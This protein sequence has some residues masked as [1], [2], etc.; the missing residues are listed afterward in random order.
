MNSVSSTSSISTMNNKETENL[1]DEMLKKIKLRDSTQFHYHKD[2]KPFTKS[3]LKYLR[4][5]VSRLKL[6]KQPEQRSKEW[7][8]MRENKITASDIATAIDESKYQ[9]RLCIT[10]EKSNK[11]S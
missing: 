8:E 5:Q 2:L 4:E 6:I 1:S 3:R 11:R 7:F 9:K 10:K